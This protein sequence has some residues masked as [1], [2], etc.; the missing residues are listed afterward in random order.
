MKKRIV[1][2]IL[3]CVIIAVQTFA[4]Q[5]KPNIVVILADDL[6]F[7]DIG[8]FGSEIHTPVLDK[9]AK[10][11]LVM[12][13]FY[14][15]ARCCPSRA[16]LL[17]GLYP[18]QAGVGDMVQNKGS[19][20]YQGFLNSNC[21]TMGE[22]LKTGGYNTIV[23]GKWH[24]GLVPSAW[25]V[26]RGFDKSFTLQ[27]NGSSY[28]NS[29]PLYN[30][31]RVVT[32]LLNGQEV[33]R[34]DTSLYLTQAITNFALKSLDEIK[35]QP[36][37][38][39]LYVAYNAPHWPIQALPEDIA[40]YKGKYLNGW[41]ELRLRRYKK[42]QALGIIKKEWVLS[43]RFENVKA[44][45]S[46]SEPEKE[47][48]DTRMA[49]YAAMI[50]RMDAG[51][52]QILDKI[53]ELKKDK[54]T[55]VVF[56]SDNG[57]S[58]DEVKNWDYVT[59]KNGVP[60]SVNS[61]DSYEAP[62]GNASNTPFRL[63]KKNTHEG[64]ISSP[65]IAY[66]PGLIEA[67]SSSDLPA[68]FID[69]LPTLLELSGIEYPETFKGNPLTKLEGRSLLDVFKGK[70]TGRND[71]F[72]WEHE[73]SRAIRDG[74]WKLVAELNAPWE[75]YNLKTDRTEVYD[76]ATKYPDRVKQME[77]KYQIWAAKVGVRDWNKIK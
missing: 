46:L 11:G 36:N 26:N 15:A 2:L 62:W 24:V 34:Q 12:S 43:P 40:K 30:D 39:L 44:W 63:F 5:A 18:H 29:Q 56:L 9:L 16:A 45:S 49:I 57:G 41:D 3:F 59:Q 4:Q 7:S 20:A 51:I 25:A 33:Q 73:G 22:L 77:K 10:Q 68:H 72:Y 17:T 53:K 8:A 27:N 76:L 64:G 61:I 19:E 35:D 47:L 50:D 14:N 38:F 31:G 28:F 71:A 37:P 70:K 21:A 65:F 75:L 6:G 55:L 67:G 60:G 13:Q 52:G 48:W 74:D 66:Y 54:N 58:A 32:F 1:I 42:L 23:S 69:L